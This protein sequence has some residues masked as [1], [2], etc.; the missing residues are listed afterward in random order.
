MKLAAP[1]ERTRWINVIGFEVCVCVVCEGIYKS[2]T[3][4]RTGTHTRL[5]V[6]LS[7]EARSELWIFRGSGVELAKCGTAI[8]ARLFVQ[9][10]SRT[11][12]RAWYLK[13]CDAGE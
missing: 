9:V 10:A 5:D 3:L 12:L 13:K 7:A 4:R 8:K 11:C 1:N 2:V 6:G